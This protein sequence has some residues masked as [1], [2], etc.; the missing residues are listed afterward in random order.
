ME[1]KPKNRVISVTF[2]KLSGKYYTKGE[3]VVNHY[4]FEKEY[5][6]D[7]VNTQNAMI[8]GWQGRY[9][10]LTSCD[11]LKTREF[12]ENLFTPEQFRMIAKQ[13]IENKVREVIEL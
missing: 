4:L 9:Y 7:I 12:H 5:L 8:D 10:V 13:N 2:F 6:Q 3:A 1:D 11:D